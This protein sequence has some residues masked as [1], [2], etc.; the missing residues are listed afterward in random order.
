[1]SSKKTLLNSLIYI[2]LGFLAP[3]V[4]FILLPIYTHYL[5][6]QDYALITQSAL[7]QSVFVNIL[8]FG[9]NAAFA[10]YFFDFYKEPE[11]L[12]ELYSTTIISYLISGSVIIAVFS[13]IGEWILDISFSN[14]VFTYWGY[15]FF[16]VSTALMANLQLISLSYYRNQEKALNYAV[17]AIMFF[18]SVASCIYIGVVVMELKAKG[19]IVGR[20]VGTLIPIMLYVIWFYRKRSI[21][22]SV[23]LNKQ[24]LIYGLPLVPYLLLNVVLDQADKYAVERFF[25]MTI[26]GLYGFGFL[27]ASVN[28]IF[29]NS[30]NAALSPQVYK[31][32]G[33]DEIADLTKVRKLI[34]IYVSAGVAINIGITVAGAL[35]IHYLLNDNYKPVAAFFPLLSLAYIPR[36]F[37]TAYQMPVFYNKQTRVMPFINML[38]LVVYV[39]GFIIAAPVLGIYGVCIATILI[40]L[41]Q[42]VSLYLFIRRKKMDVRRVSIFELRNEYIISLLLFVY[43]GTWYIV[44]PQLGEEYRFLWLV[45]LLFTALPYLGIRIL[46]VSG[47]NIR[48]AVTKF[49]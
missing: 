31:N 2:I 48:E 6:A 21:K 38:T 32:L 16:S 12:D 49:L 34:N 42:M 3:A 13:V 36:V 46:Q 24:M 5:E 25:D 41:T 20:F 44:S 9:I 14:K 7:I 17:L 28:D 19:S 30:I 29:I 1:M 10:R 18:L 37:F 26:L 22:Y 11:K 33:S 40:K 27:I 23:L 39:I 45:P 4:N 47:I 15:G 35:G 43:M 8:G